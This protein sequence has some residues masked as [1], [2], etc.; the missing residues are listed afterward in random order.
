MKSPTN[1]SK[2]EE[3]QKIYILEAML[4]ITKSAI[5]F[6]WTDETL[7]NRILYSIIHLFGKFNSELISFD[8]SFWISRFI[9]S[10]KNEYK[11]EL[12]NIYDSVL[13]I[14]EVLSMLR[15][16]IQIIKYK[17]GINNFLILH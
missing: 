1:K 5:D 16:N 7:N 3:L 11:A 10:L 15:L 17:T 12:H 2:K 4:E 6:G 8:K 13:G 9:Y 14:I